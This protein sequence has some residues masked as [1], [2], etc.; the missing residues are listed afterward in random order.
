[1]KK[2]ISKKSAFIS[3]FAIVLGAF[4]SYYGYYDRISCKPNQAG[5]WYIIVL[6]F[7]FGVMVTLFGFWMDERKNSKKEK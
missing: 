5:F 3:S 7:T 6:G 4:A 2:P 1:M